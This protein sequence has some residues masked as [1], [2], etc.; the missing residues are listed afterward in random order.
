[1]V[2][3]SCWL[4]EVLLVLVVTVAG[5]GALCPERGDGGPVADVLVDASYPAVL[6]GEQGDLR[7]VERAPVRAGAADLNEHANAARAVGHEGPR[8]RAQGARGQL[9][10]LGQVRGDPVAA[11]VAATEP[12]VV[13]VIPGRV[14][15]EQRA[16]RREVTA[17]EGVED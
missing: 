4:M 13:A 2:R 5:P 14:L 17:G 6:D 15:V 9:G 7:V 1:M 12:V 11:P 3:L 8:Y 10:G 16:E